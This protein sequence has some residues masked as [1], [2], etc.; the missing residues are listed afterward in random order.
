MVLK[1]VYSIH[2]VLKLVLFS[3][4]LIG[5]T[6]LIFESTSAATIHVPSEYPSIQVAIDAANESDT[7]YVSSGTYNE[8]VIINKSLTL[9]GED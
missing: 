6:I 1:S 3:C 5:S 8:N 2:Y 9:T 7:I 4:A